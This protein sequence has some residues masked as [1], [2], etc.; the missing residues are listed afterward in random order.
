MPHI[1]RRYDPVGAVEIELAKHAAAVA[2]FCAR[3]ISD[4]V[5]RAT[6]F[7]LGYRGA[8]LASEFR[9]RYDL[10]HENETQ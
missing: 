3:T 6:L 1:N 9:Y 4:D 8:A 5:F 7:G 2:E 10:R